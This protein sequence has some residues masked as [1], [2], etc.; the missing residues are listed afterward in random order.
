MR[1]I[2]LTIILVVTAI[3]V[4]FA[5]EKAFNSESFILEN[6]MEVVII[7]NHR[8]PVVTHMLWYKIGAAD[9]PKGKSGLAHFLEHLMFKGTENIPSGQFSEII[10][11]LGGNENAFTSY[12]YTAYFQSI[13]VEH[14]EKVMSMEADRMRGL[15]LTDQDIESERLVVLEERRQRTENNPENHFIEQM[16]HALFANHGYG[17]PV[18]GWSHEIENLTYDDIR[19]FYNDWY[20]PNNA[21]LIVSG[22]V[23]SETIRPIVEKTYGKIAARDVPEHIRTEIPPLPGQYRPLIRH[24]QIKQPSFRRIIRVPSYNQ[25]KKTS[26]ALQALERIMSDGASTR[27][28]K[29]LVVEK[30]I[31]TSVSMS[32]DGNSINDSKMWIY[33]LPAKNVTLEE[34]EN[35]IDYELR[36]V[37]ENG[38]SEDE[39]KRAKIKMQNDA[40]FARDSITGPAMIFGRALV[41]GS[42]IDDIE[43][44]AHNVNNVTTEQILEAA[45]EYINPENINGRPQVSAYFLPAETPVKT[46]DAK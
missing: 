2:I 11:K 18:I 8:I 20:A 33:G 15:I 21:I 23:T 45:K 38:V 46:K 26:L 9:E 16:M 5:R 1:F 25:D 30:K 40:I 34:L 17:I 12:D 24:E 36:K 39:L 28:Y 6:G 41:T 10:L 4:S 35:A 42:A 37:I 19:S 22:D 31:A 27:L 43:Y 44:W 14:L 29:S 13:A 32:Y 3:P 7:P